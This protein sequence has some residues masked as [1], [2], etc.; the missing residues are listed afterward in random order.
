MKVYQ[1]LLPLAA[2]MMLVGCGRSTAERVIMQ[3]DGAVTTLKDEAATSAPAELKTA[4]ATLAHMKQ[5]FD[6]HDYK[7]VVADVPQFNTQMNTL[8]E[9]I[10]TKNGAVA[11]ATME[12]STLNTEVPKSVEA[13]Q[14]R[15]DSLK[16]N[17]LPKEVTK[18]TLA[19]AKTELE[20]AKA[21]WAEATAAASAGHTVEATEK[22]RIVQ[23]KVEELKNQLKMSEQ[24]ASA[25]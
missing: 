19:T 7:V 17:A 18:E 21:T 6:A 13:V 9:A 20:T 15:V 12:W 10:A 3:A 16:P 1:A 5:S 22:G 23:A 11:A 14:A 25:G 8:K 24:L 4:E 2:A